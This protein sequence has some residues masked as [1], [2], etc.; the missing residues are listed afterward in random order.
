[1]FISVLAVNLFSIVNFFKRQ[2][3]NH[4]GNRCPNQKITKRS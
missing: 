3:N 4:A 1:M 2:H